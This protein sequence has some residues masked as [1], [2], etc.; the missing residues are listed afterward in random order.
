MKTKTQIKKEIKNLGILEEN[1]S[2]HKYQ[3]FYYRERKILLWVL[4]GD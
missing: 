2:T 4:D 3:E 1:A